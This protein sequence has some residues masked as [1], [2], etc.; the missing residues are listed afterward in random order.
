MRALLFILLQAIPTFAASFSA[1]SFFHS[2]PTKFHDSKNGQYHLVLEDV[3]Q[4]RGVAS[5]KLR[6]T[7]FGPLTNALWQIEFHG[8][9][10][11]VFTTE[12]IIVSERGDFFLMTPA[13]P[14]QWLLYAKDGK[15][16]VLPRPQRKIP[17]D[18][19]LLDNL[20]FVDSVDGTNVVNVWDWNSDQ[21]ETSLLP[22]LASVKVTP[23]LAAQWNERMRLQIIDMLHL[24]NLDKARRKLD[25]YSTRL[26]E[27]ATNVAP[28]VN[29][30][31]VHDIHYQFLALRRHPSDRSIFEEFLVP[32]IDP[33][34]R[35]MP[36]PA[37][38]SWRG[39]DWGLRTTPGAYQDQWPYRFSYYN[40]HYLEGDS[41]LAL[42]DQK[43]SVTNII[44]N[45]ID[46]PLFY[47]GKA[48]GKI[49]LPIPLVKKSGVLRVL[50]IPDAWRGK[51]SPLAQFVDTY[52]NVLI[53]VLP[54]R[55]PPSDQI[56]FTFESIHPGIYRLKAI[57]DKRSPFF[58]DY[59]HAGPGDYESPW[60]D[61]ITVAAGTT[62]SKLLLICT[63]RS[64]LPGGE[65]YYAADDLS[66][67]LTSPAQNQTAK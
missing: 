23:A 20:A 3:V 34:P 7:L 1:E 51:K 26:T 21:W 64:T 30:T 39:S 45:S 36:L 4:S 17:P 33:P 63:N 65:A 29:G 14:T 61:S 6:A 57:W 5:G 35:G 60:S 59:E 25:G 55:L 43:I 2:R 56:T 12:R 49:Q 38:Y 48:T 41:Y 31:L 40:R 37:G 11:N 10:A 52:D 32:R 24:E 44:K 15:P 67:R 18:P 58:N 8:P 22:C 42:F 50:L 54:A 9:N 66:L 16:Q 13:M 62:L 46:E 47:L 19:W 27:L 28:V 53:P